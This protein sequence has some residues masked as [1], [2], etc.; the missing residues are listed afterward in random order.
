MPKSIEIDCQTGEQKIVDVPDVITN[1]D[2][3][4][5]ELKAYKISDIME[6]YKSLIKAGLTST[7]TGSPIEFGY[8]QQDQLNYSKWANVFS[9][10]TNRVSVTVGSVSNGVI[11]LTRSQFLQ[12]MSDAEQHEMGLYTKRIDLENKINSAQTIDDLN[13]IPSVLE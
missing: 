10:D 7:A 1:N 8:S 13:L 4:L 5:D 9:L 11:E 12:F 6:S 2:L 3:S